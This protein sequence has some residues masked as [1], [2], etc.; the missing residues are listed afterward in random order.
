MCHARD[1]DLGEAKER[2]RAIEPELDTETLVFFHTF[3]RGG[4]PLRVFLTDRLRKAARKEGVWRSPAMLSTLKNAAYGLDERAARSV[5]GR[6][7]IFIVDRSFRPANAMM[8]KLFDRFLD[9]GDSEARA[10]ARAL[11]AKLEEL[12]PV[13]LV[14]HHMRLLGVLA[15][16]VDEDRLALVDCDRG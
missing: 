6:D 13:R 5:G 8:T 1:V 2:L 16:D 7:G 10:I 9:K 12:V 3:E 15:R 4:R 14:S 11:E